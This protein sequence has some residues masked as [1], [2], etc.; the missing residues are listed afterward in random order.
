MRRTLILCLILISVVLVTS[1]H[2]PT[3]SYVGY[4]L[5]P[6]TLKTEGRINVE[7]PGLGQQTTVWLDKFS[8]PHI[9]ANSEHDLYFA[10]GYMQGRDRRFQME[11][12]KSVATGR[13]RELIGDQDK[14]GMMAQLEIRS[15]MVGLYLDAQ[16]LLEVLPPEDLALMEAFAEGVNAATA[17]EPTP[18]EFRLL[19]VK[20]EPWKAVD[21]GAIV[22][23]TAF[24]LCK[25]WE[26]ELARLE[27][28][29]HQLRTGSDV[30]RILAIWEPRQ[31]LPPHLIG[32]KPE[33]DPFADIPGIAPELTEYLIEYTK[34]YP[35]IE[36][37][38]PIQEETADSVDVSWSPLEQ[39]ASASNNWAMSGDWTETGHAALS[40]DPH[41][42]LTLPSLGYLAHLECD[43]CQEGS[44]KVIG[45]GFAGL[46][47]ITFGS[48]GAVAWG[49]T[50]N[51]A[52]VTDVFVEKQNP[53]QPDQVF[54][55]G[56]SELI[57][58]REEI[59]K[60]RQNDGTFLT[61]KRIARYTRHGML[62][63]DFVERLPDKFPLVALKRSYDVGRPISA[64]R[65][66]Y[67][68]KS[69]Q[70]ARKAMDGFAAMTAHWALAD[71]S[72]SVG[73]MQTVRL[74]VRK[75][76][77][78]TVPVPG[79]VKTYEWNEYLDS[80]QAPSVFNPPQGFIGT[81]NNQVIQPEFFGLPINFE[82]DI[83]H[84]YA[85]IAQVL[86]KGSDGSSPVSQIANLQLDGVDLG[87]EDLRE[88]LVQA[89]DPLKDEPNRPIAEAVKKLLDWDGRSE[90]KSAGP[91]IFHSLVAH[92]VKEVM[93]DEVS[94]KTMEFVLTYFNVEPLVYA[95]LSDHQNPA[96][97]DRRTEKV[98]TAD[99]II[100]AVFKKTISALSEA[101]GPALAE[102]TWEEAAPFYLKHPFG[103]MK[104]LAKYLNRGPFPTTGGVNTV[105]KQQFERELMT[106][107]PV[108]HGP[109][110]RVMIDL[111]DLPG[112][113]MSLPGG[114]SGRPSS[115]HYD[116]LIE[117]YF[118]GGGVPMD[119]DWQRI[120]DEAVARLVL[121]PIGEN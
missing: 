104:A 25:N 23:L 69:V 84:R 107:F 36:N 52:D 31:N 61:E 91:V 32:V 80:E 20:P 82:G 15:R 71:S 65:Q 81:A 26:Q 33:V 79:W 24:G 68:S 11:L 105:F 19:G 34:L 90:P 100:P 51:W 83:P 13:L 70:E 48:N 117:Y 64:F 98:E 92:L 96:W 109:V 17:N 59:F 99:Q 3:L 94:G 10:Y 6:D 89:L 4:R 87:I 101:Y 7:V 55:E 39:G 47:A 85:R 116:D 12:L 63:N 66:V 115:A 112:S 56:Q 14:S 86:G 35:Q 46:P 43:G 110:L 29:V 21:S 119:M 93:Q 108:K 42:P 8:V 74:P 67:N 44:Y 95:I 45:G 54:Y 97:D 88:I 111:G 120:K 30:N 113:V 27:M 102:W 72:G 78:G 2:S 38:L 9:Q 121:L 16:R 62:I 37:S 60:I 22:A 106:S 73:Y 18:L 75:N 49:A 57:Q 58:Q 28:M 118:T 53:D 1:C 114:Q 5:A 77:L 40:S 76:H 103:Q 41:M 50:S